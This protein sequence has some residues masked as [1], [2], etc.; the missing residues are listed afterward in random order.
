MRR[1]NADSR[2]KCKR[3]PPNESA[4]SGERFVPDCGQCRRRRNGFGVD[5]KMD[6]RRSAGSASSG[7]C[8]R[9]IGA[10]LD[11]G[12]ITSKRHGVRDKIGIAQLRGDDAARI[13]TLLMHP[14]SAIYS[15]ISHNYDN[16]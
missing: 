8:G 15:V 16:W 5:F 4:A 7:E 9:K 13:F 3:T 10:F 1:V 6:N 2:K 11:D 14:D 12:A